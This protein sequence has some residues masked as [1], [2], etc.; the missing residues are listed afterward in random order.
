MYLP[1]ICSTIYKYITHHEWSN[2]GQKTGDFMEANTIR[3]VEKTIS[4]FS[5]WT[6]VSMLP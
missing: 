6:Y 3:Q 4:P 2:S 5:Q 1:L